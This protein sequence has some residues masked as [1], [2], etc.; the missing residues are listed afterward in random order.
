MQKINLGTL[1]LGF[2][3]LPLLQRSLRSKKCQ[4][5]SNSLHSELLKIVKKVKKAIKS[6][7]TSTKSLKSP[8]DWNVYSV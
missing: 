7:Q 5:K 4:R 8:I 3:T 6:E 1:E 2:E